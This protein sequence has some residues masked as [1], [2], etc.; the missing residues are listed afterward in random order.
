MV[1]ASWISS[2][3][4]RGTSL[5]EV[6]MNSLNSRIASSVVCG[7][8][9]VLI[10]IVHA[11]TSMGKRAAVGEERASQIE[12]VLGALYPSGRV[13]RALLDFDLGCPVLRF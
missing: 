2:A 8:A 13:A 6:S 7:V 12:A 3:I 1:I 10:P 11:Q 5:G 4:T 9:L